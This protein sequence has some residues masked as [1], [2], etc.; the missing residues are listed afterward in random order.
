MKTRAMVVAMLTIMGLVAL[1]A[2]FAQADF[3]TCTISQ[4][5]S[6]A[7]GY[8]IQVTDTGS[9]VQFTNRN[10]IIEE[11]MGKGKEML[12][13]ALT[14]FANSTNVQIWVDPPY[15]DMSLAWSVVA[16]K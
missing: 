8:V 16:V 3:R 15:T 12:A 7:S 5:G 6:Y 4:V 9:P 11:S 2:G 13:A 14:A 10:F 1:S